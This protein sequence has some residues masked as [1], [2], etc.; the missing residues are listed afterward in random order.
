VRDARTRRRAAAAWLAVAL[1]AAAT[2]G[3][4]PSHLLT[5]DEVEIALE[6]SPL[7][8]PPPDP[9]NAWADDPA[10]ARL[11]QALF[12]DERLSGTG[13]VSCATCHDPDRGFSDGRR[14]AEAVAHHPRHTM[15]LWNVAHN[16]WF[17][18]DGRKDTLWSQALAPWEDPR[19]HASSRLEI[20]HVIASDPDYVRAYEQTFGPLPDLDDRDRF[21][22]RGR[23]V[24][25]EETHPDALAWAAMDEADRALVDDVFVHLGKAVA[26]YERRIVSRHA[27]FDTFVEGLREGDA[28]KLDA[29]SE[30]AQRG[31]S[32][33]VG[34]ARCLFCHDG[35]SFTDKEFHANRVPTGEGVDPGR[36]LGVMRLLEDPF[37]SRSRF[38]DDGGAS[39]R[40]KLSLTRPEWELPGR[41]KTPT[42]RN[43]ATTAPYMHEG[44]IATLEEVVGFYATLEDA[45]PPGPHP[46]KLLV[47]LGLTERE[48]ADLVAFLESLT[49]ESLPASLRRAP[50]TPYLE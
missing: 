16:R 26:A 17:F 32:L 42:L 9:T 31:F 35:P 29:L 34:D 37:N 4:D 45:A 27:P 11:G 39:G 47:P 19:E 2:T 21:P 22:P 24:P 33:F 46:E 6:L 5:P 7:P 23:P 41:F 20:V 49:D 3:D 38:A 44:Q 40:T 30:P 10:A 8:D 14:L 36:P 43:V 1:P 28:G 12:F 25:G 13:T 50:R 48:K 18:W 15:S